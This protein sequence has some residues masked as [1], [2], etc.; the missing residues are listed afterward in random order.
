[1]SA[2]DDGLIA[3]WIPV[4]GD[5][6]SKLLDCSP[7]RAHGSVGGMTWQDIGGIKNA[8]YNNAS[9]TPATVA[10]NGRIKRS[11]P[12]SFA[13]WYYFS[14]L[15]SSRSL[16]VTSTRSSSNNGGFGAAALSTT[17]LQLVY[18]DNTANTTA[19]G[20]VQFTT[21]TGVLAAGAWYHIAGVFHQHLVAEA[22]IDGVQQSLTQA[23]T[24]GAVVH[25]VNGI[26]VG[27]GTLV[28]VS[29]THLTLPT[30]A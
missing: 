20:I 17:A 1:M 3:A 25:N 19:S 4:L 11:Y 14:G 7:T 6:G 2:F 29:Y 16:F 26:V 18:A 8:L 28:A 5:T 22:W 12:F 9:V 23:G 21:N 13:G 15:N 30:K 10:A 24:G 27:G